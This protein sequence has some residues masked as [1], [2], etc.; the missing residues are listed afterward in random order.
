[1]DSYALLTVHCTLS[2]IQYNTTQY[3]TTQYNTT[4]NNTTHYNTGPV[5]CTGLEGPP[6]N[7]LCIYICLGDPKHV[8]T[9][10]SGQQSIALLA[11]GVKGT[12][13]RVLAVCHFWNIIRT[14]Y[15]ASPLLT[16]CLSPSIRT[17][18]T[19]STLST[20]IDGISLDY[21]PLSK[22]ASYNEIR[23][24]VIIETQR[25]LGLP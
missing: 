8:I 4:Q 17:L 12:Q 7:L 25:R 5:R 11:S 3:N 13:S 19:W 18:I 15:S 16:T 21:L 23:F 10:Y 1:M 6:K 2:I 22:Y 20:G 24:L 14:C 9:Q